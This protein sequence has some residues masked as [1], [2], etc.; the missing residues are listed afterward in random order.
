ME[1]P[2]SPVV[3][4]CGVRLRVGVRGGHGRVDSEVYSEEE[5]GDAQSIRP[6]RRVWAEAGSDV[7]HAGYERSVCALFVRSWWSCSLI[8]RLRELCLF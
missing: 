8:L 5:G 3:V 7:V 2:K 6:T 1:W 4:S